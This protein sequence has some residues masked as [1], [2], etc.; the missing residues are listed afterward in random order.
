MW[1][2]APKQRGHVR[3]ALDRIPP[4]GYLLWIVFQLVPY[5][6]FARLPPRDHDIPI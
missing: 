1:H 5:D 2:P 3:C 6:C 4:V